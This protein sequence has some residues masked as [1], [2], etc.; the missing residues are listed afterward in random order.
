VEGFQNLRDLLSSSFMTIV[1]GSLLSRQF[2]TYRLHPNELM[3]L[4]HPQ[5]SR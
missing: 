3:S 5:I 1:S 4:G 2:S